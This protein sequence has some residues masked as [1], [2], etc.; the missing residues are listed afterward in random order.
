MKSLPEAPDTQE[1]SPIIKADK[2]HE[3]TR[4][5]LGQDLSILSEI[6]KRFAVRCVCHP[7]S[8]PLAISIP[9]LPPIRNFYDSSITLPNH[10]EALISDPK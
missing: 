7:S 5:N 6:S 4:K 8:M 10:D 2:A 9:P 1:T 3:V